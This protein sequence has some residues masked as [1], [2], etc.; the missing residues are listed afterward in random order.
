MGSTDQ[1]THKF[2]AEIVKKVEQI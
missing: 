2:Y 1:K